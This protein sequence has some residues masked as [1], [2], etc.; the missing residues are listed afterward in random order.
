MQEHRLLATWVFLVGG[1]FLLVVVT[2][3]TFVGNMSN[4]FFKSLI[5]WREF[6]IPTPFN[7]I[8]GVGKF[9]DMRELG[10]YIYRATGGLF[11]ILVY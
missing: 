5:L 7:H 11:S 1:T 10:S 6:K 2:M 8:M 9:R 4:I 3:L